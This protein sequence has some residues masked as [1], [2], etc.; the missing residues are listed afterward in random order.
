ME[1][2]RG[3]NCNPPK[4]GQATIGGIIRDYVLGGDQVD[5][6]FLLYYELKLTLANIKKN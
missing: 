2:Y 4:K 5:F 1:A 6:F 3:A